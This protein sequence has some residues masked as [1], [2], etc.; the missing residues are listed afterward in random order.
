MRAVKRI[1]EEEVF[2]V[3]LLAVFGVVILLVFPPYLLV[4]DSWLMLAAGR[5]I[6]DY[7]FPAAEY[8]HP[9]RSHGTLM[10][11]YRHRAHDDNGT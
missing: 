11:H 2:L 3:L 7:G 8:Y 6:I 5:E 10:C 1:A 9:Q 4:S